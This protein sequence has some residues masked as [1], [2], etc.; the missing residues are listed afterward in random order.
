MKTKTRIHPV[1]TLAATV[2]GED[3]NCGDYVALLNET[4]CL[5]GYLANF[6]GCGEGG[7]APQESIRYQ[8]IPENAGQ[9]LK[10]IA[11]CLP[12]VYGTTASGGTVIIDI[13]RF[14]VVRLDRDCAKTIWK[15]IES[16]AN[17]QIAPPLC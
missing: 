7:F 4:I 13:R 15:Q 9:P 11:I 14:Q 8:S 6:F 12:F 10:V 5:P 17:R 16:E 2:A 3:L 1:P